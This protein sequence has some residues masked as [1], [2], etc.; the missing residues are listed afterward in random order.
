MSARPRWEI[1]PG[2]L[3]RLRRAL[4]RVADRAELDATLEA[5]AGWALA[6][7]D[8][9]AILIALRQPP[10]DGMTVRASAGRG[11][12]RLVGR[13][14]EALALEAAPGAGP[15]LRVPIAGRGA[16]ENGPAARP[17]APAGEAGV[18]IARPR[19]GRPLDAGDAEL[20]R[21]LAT[22]A[23]IA[24]AQ[25]QADQQIARLY[26]LE[27]RRAE[28]LAAA[29]E[30]GRNLVSLQRLGDVLD[31][32]V[33]V[34][35]SRFG[36]DRVAIYLRDDQA[37]DFVL[38]AAAGSGPR[39]G[40]RLDLTQ[41]TAAA[42][43]ARHGESQ[44]IA[45]RERI[46][47]TRL[48]GELEVAGELAVPIGDRAQPTGVLAL[49]SAR[50]GAF[51]GGDLALA[52]AIGDEL[53]IAIQNL[54]LAAQARDDAAAAERARLARELH[55][56]TAQQLVAIARQ[57]D[58]LGASDDS[59]VVEQVDRIHE[60]VDGA[61]RNVRRISRDLR[62]AVLEDLGLV[63]ALEAIVAD[64]QR[65]GGPAV[66]LAVGGPSRP[67]PAR[68]ELALYRIAHQALANSL[69]HA[70]ASR[71]AIELRFDP[72]AV[73]LAVRDDGRGFAMPTNLAELEKGGGLGVV[74]MRERANEVG[75]RLEI[76]TAPGVGTLVRVRVPS[77]A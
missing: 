75:G 41:P 46:D 9:G 49:A 39:P 52:E 57:L 11:T 26:E 74:G 43:A 16:A 5:L 70:T 37:S 20:L 12:R 17:G 60:L 44:L 3:Q 7:L 59:A 4:G 1:T 30:V 47:G 45:D 73:T 56:D 21:L 35:K 34:L 61:L 63:A 67:L 64:A 77:P 68:T 65:R 54:R 69:A 29:A 2:E 6:L 50:S 24:L 72:E 51:D 18:V 31:F 42:W 55:D 36:Y 62:P 13:P 14:L 33:G 25:H 23:A 38:R 58:L 28:Q 76:E 48:L 22:Q 15:W 71:V 10:G 32:A 40:G 8:A 66:E 19:R 53:G 27:R